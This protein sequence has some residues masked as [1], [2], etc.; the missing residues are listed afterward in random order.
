MFWTLESRRS[1]L[2]RESPES[3][4][5]MML[6]PEMQTELKRRI[7]IVEDE[8]FIAITLEDMLTDLGFI[9]AS[10]SKICQALDFIARERFDA[11]L[12]DVSLGS[13]KI[14]P[15]AE[16][17]AQRACPFIFTTGHD[18]TEVPAAYA[19]HVVI[20]KPYKMAELEKALRLELKMADQ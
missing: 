1:T 16:L 13:Q 4:P 19:D 3:L 6:P 14:D 5:K 8:P 11:A 17:L 18:R 15:V 7:L 9:A 20:Q 10:C 2:L 12:L